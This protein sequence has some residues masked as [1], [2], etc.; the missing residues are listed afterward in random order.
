MNEV[1]HGTTEELLA[2]RD[3]EGS[4]WA[5][6]HV[7][8][9]GACARELYR[10]EQVRAQLRALPALASPRDRWAPIAERARRERLQRRFSGGVGLAAAAALAGLLLVAVQG[11]HPDPLLAETTLKTAMAR[12]QAMEQVLR[13]L[14]PDARA[15]TGGAAGAV[16]DLQLRIEALDAQLNDPDGWGNDRAR[17]SELWNERAGLLSAL[18]DVHRTRVAYAGL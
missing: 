11:T 16:V 13:D 3:G 15:L 12:S 2:L 18:V 4:A 6:T 17:Q 5:K 9:C 7:E 1:R 8:S 14:D 10:L